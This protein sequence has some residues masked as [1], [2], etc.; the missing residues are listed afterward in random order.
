M[1]SLVLSFVLSLV[2]SLD[3]PD[4]AELASSCQTEALAFLCKILDKVPGVSAHFDSQ[5]TI[6]LYNLLR[7]LTYNT[8]ISPAFRRIICSHV[9]AG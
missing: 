7:N 3:H 2:L 6:T 5:I 1:L 9:S 8:D 4:P